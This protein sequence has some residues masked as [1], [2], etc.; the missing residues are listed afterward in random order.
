MVPDLVLEK[1]PLGYDRRVAELVVSSFVGEVE[2]LQDL[3]SE[4]FDEA[5]ERFATRRKL[6]ET[7]ELELR[8]LTERRVLKD[9]GFDFSKDTETLQRA[10]EA[11][12]FNK[13][14]LDKMLREYDP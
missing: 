8:E 14:W 3:L 13:E 9:C 5:L 4:K 12:I 1:K 11:G 6:K 2:Q 10:Y 7:P